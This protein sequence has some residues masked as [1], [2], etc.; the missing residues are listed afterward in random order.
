MAALAR[1][2]RP[3]FEIMAELE[4]TEHDDRVRWQ[5]AG[6]NDP[7]PCGSDRKYKHC[8]LLTRRR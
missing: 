5:M 2:R 1:Q 7:C 6:R 4:E 3:I 8:C